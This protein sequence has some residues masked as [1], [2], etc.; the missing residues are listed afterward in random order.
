MYEIDWI[1]TLVYFVCSGVF[2][3]VGLCSK[4]FLCSIFN[5][6][7]FGRDDFGFIVSEITPLFF[8][9]YTACYFIVN[10]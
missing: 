6:E 8:I 2:A 10:K 9:G 5:R 4:V 7:W 1:T 3:A